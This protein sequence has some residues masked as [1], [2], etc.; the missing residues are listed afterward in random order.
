MKQIY[1]KHTTT[2]MP[3]YNF[4]SIRIGAHGPRARAKNSRAK[5]FVFLH[6]QEYCFRTTMFTEEIMCEKK[7][8]CRLTG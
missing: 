5:S 4:W 2:L 3:C 7:R 6:L 8:F 1:Y